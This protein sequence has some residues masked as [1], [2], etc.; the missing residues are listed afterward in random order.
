[1][2]MDINL[3]DAIDTS[4][5]RTVQYSGSS[6]F[7]NPMMLLNFPDFKCPVWEIPPV[8]WSPRSSELAGLGIEFERQMYVCGR[9]FRCGGAYSEANV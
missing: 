1:M 9:D 3:N 7:V 8:I 4:K 2:G 5:V 6:M